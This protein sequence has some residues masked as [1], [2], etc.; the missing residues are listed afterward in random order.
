VAEATTSLQGPQPSCRTMQMLTGRAYTSYLIQVKYT[1][2]SWVVRRRYKD[3]LSLHKDINDGECLGGQKTR[4]PA[5]SA[6][7]SILI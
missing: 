6:N 5:N 1:N 3:V 2:S 4:D 7:V